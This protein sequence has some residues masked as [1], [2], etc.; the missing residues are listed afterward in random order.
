MNHKAQLAAFTILLAI[1]VF[2]KH[3]KVANISN[4]NKLEIV[5]SNINFKH[6][7]ICNSDLR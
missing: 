1:W 7:L 2:R 6:E 3:S 5:T 4:E